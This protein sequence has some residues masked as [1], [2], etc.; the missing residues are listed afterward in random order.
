MVRA[1]FLF[2]VGALLSLPASA[3][4]LWRFVGPEG[5]TL[6]AAAIELQQTGMLG[7]HLLDDAALNAT[8]A[9][10]KL[11]ADL[12][13]LEDNGTCEDPR[14]AVLQLAG[15]SARIDATMGVGDN[16]TRT[17]TLRVLSANPNVAPRDHTGRGA[18]VAEALA[19]AVGDL[20]G[21]ATVEVSVTPNDARIYLG[22]T[23]LGVGSGRYPVPPGS[24]EIRAEAEGFSP[25]TQTLEFRAGTVVQVNFM[26][27][28]S[29]GELTLTTEPADAQVSLNGKPL[30][31]QM[32][33]H[34]M[35]PGEYQLRVEAPG[36]VTHEQTITIKPSTLLTLSVKLPQESQDFWSRFATPHPDTLANRFYV[37]SDLRFISVADGPMDSGGV[38][39]VDESIGLIGLAV[40]VGYRGRYLIVEALN[41]TYA[42]GGGRTQF[43]GGSDVPGAEPEFFINELARW[44]IRPAWIGARYPSWRFDPYIMGGIELTFEDFDVETGQRIDNASKS[45]LLLGVE[46][47][48]RVQIMPEWFISASGVFDFAPETRSS[49][50]F[51]VGAGYGFDVP[52]LFE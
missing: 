46:A 20:E 3:T 21:Q 12:G 16:D 28:S 9:D 36:R 1:V 32:K 44:T 26:L 4:T 13:C 8:L 49:A 41:I 42:G 23:P 33:S 48:L 40:G 18:T 10:A 17:V 38:D 35:A 45:D 52:G 34:P 31:T 5:E 29:Y 15:L 24:H 7:D 22:Q 11:P 2:M 6:R 19:Q 30:L 37:R 25:L 27:G 39:T 50:A 51:V 43:D 14:Q 47:G